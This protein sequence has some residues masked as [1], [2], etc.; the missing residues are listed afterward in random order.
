MEN[1]NFGRILF[2]F[3]LSVLKAIDNL[4]FMSHTSINRRKFLSKSAMSLFGYSLMVSVPAS[5]DAKG[6]TAAISDV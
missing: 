2:R 4:T 3:L 5:P 6:G 1:A